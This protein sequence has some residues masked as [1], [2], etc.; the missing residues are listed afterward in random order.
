MAV[1]SKTMKQ[2]FKKLLSVARKQAVSVRDYAQATTAS[3][4]VKQ[5]NASNS[6]MYALEPRIMF[7]AAALTTAVETIAEAEP[8][9]T[10][11][12][13]APDAQLLVDGITQVQPVNSVLFVD[14]AVQ[15][16]QS[17][18]NGVQAG[19]QVVILDANQDGVQQI[20][21]T[22]SQYSNL[23]SIQIISHG[24]Q[25]QLSLGNASLSQSS[26]DSYQTALQ[27]WGDAL[28]ETGDILFYG[29]N[30]AEGSAGNQ[31]IQQLSTITGADIAASN[32]NTGSAALGG[33]WVLEESTGDIE[34]GSVLDSAATNDYAAILAVVATD[35]TW[36]A[37]AGDTWTQTPDA[38]GNTLAS[39]AD[40]I[41]LDTLTTPNDA[42]GGTGYTIAT[43]GGGF[44]LDAITFRG[45]ANPTANPYVIEIWADG[46][47]ANKFTQT[48]NAGL[49][50]NAIVNF[51]L[52][53]DTN[54]NNI[55]SFKIHFLGTGG[56]GGESPWNLDLINFTTAPLNVAPAIGGT[57]T[58]QAVNDTGTVSLFSGVTV[59]DAEGDNVTATITLDTAAKGVF[60]AASLTASGFSTANGGLTYT[61]ASVTAAA[62]QADIRLLSYD[63][64][65]NRV[66][67]GSTE[68]TTFTIGIDDGTTTTNDA[69]TT[70]VSTSI[71]D[72]PT[73]IALTSSSV[74]QSGG[75]NAVVGT[76]SNTDADTGQSYTY[77]LVAGTGDTNNG[78]FNISGTSLRANNSSL[79][80][81]GTY[82]IRVNVNDGAA[83]FEEAM[84]IT[85][86]D[87]VVPTVTSVSSSTGDGSYKA[88][89]V[90]A[91]TVQFSEVVN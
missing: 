26:L 20:A 83:N 55:T 24:S 37:N 11:S 58:G 69:T 90:I 52:S 54:F 34:V 56:G 30:V 1:T 32:D 89:D 45:V 3:Q 8:A 68:T 31:F 82:N 36:L 57:S 80:A 27:S 22:L 70:V 29:C 81:A 39:T 12:D 6:K 88:G 74:N 91:V 59:S 75:V 2:Q 38:D 50:L 51:D 84:T 76:L 23:T 40:S 67:P 17:L 49:A 19:T 18:I 78:S 33:D 87:D 48:I 4:Q 28:S 64:A 43:S 85:I 5:L 53:A 21:N 25:G 9:P 65:D 46:N 13:P 77:T 14:S 44:Q 62:M 72:I 66:A 61:H 42:D 16:Y 60:T 79:L 15:D 35:A 86:V 10:E 7:D 71:N 47:S 41:Y 73:D 63:P